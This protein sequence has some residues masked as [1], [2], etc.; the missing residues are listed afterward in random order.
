M[1]CAYDA[2]AVCVC[3]LLSPVSSVKWTVLRRMIDARGQSWLS[4][5]LAPQGPGRAARRQGGEGRT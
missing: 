1:Q 3:L 5:T 4:L 2:T